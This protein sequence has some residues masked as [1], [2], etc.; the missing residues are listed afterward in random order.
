MNEVEVDDYEATLNWALEEEKLR[1]N[2]G[3]GIGSFYLIIA[4]ILIFLICLFILYLGNRKRKNQKLGLNAGNIQN[5]ENDETNEDN[6]DNG[7]DG[8][9]LSALGMMK[10]TKNLYEDELLNVMENR[11]DESPDPNIEVQDDEVDQK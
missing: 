11:D 6:E 9:A 1:S 2:R 5:G 3:D 4:S 8:S 7:T 10:D